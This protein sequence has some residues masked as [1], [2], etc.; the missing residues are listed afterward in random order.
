MLT[1]KHYLIFWKLATTIGRIACAVIP[2]GDTGL[3]NLPRSL[4]VPE[5]VTN[6]IDWISRRPGIGR[7]CEGEDFNFID[8]TDCSLLVPD[9]EKMLTNST[10]DED[11]SLFELWRQ[12]DEGN[13]NFAA[14]SSFGSC[15]VQVAML[16]GTNAM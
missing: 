14:V 6:Y 3:T 13:S 4:S 10:F 11:G 5:N 16:N 2:T 15:T 7:L 1:P 9:C 8:D 12:W